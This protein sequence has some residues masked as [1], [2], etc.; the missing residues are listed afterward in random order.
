MSESELILLQRWRDTR[1]ADAF[2]TLALRHT[3]MVFNTCRRILGNHADAEEV[4]QDCLVDLALTAVPPKTHVAG[5]LHRVATYKA[6]NRVRI[7]HR[8]KQRNHRYA[9]ENARNV[10]VDWDDLCQYLDEALAQLPDKHRSPLVMSFFE[11]QSHEAIARALGLTRGTVTYR[12]KKGIEALRKQLKRRGV[13]VTTAS[14]LGMLAIPAANAAATPP[15][16]ANGIARLALAGMK[17]QAAATA[18]T[19]TAIAKAA[20]LWGGILAMKKAIVAAAIIVAAVSTGV[21]LHTQEAPPATSAQSQQENGGELATTALSTAPVPPPE[22]SPEQPPLP[23]S[24]PAKE[25]TD[26]PKYLT[27]DGAWSVLANKYA[28]RSTECDR[29]TFTTSGSR[30]RILAQIRNTRSLK[31]ATEAMDGTIRGL[32]V[33]LDPAPELGRPA[34]Q[35]LFNEELTRLVFRERRPPSAPT[36]LVFVRVPREQ[37]TEEETLEKRKQEARQLSYPQFG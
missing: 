21:V 29:A 35:G 10:T 36:T 26:A 15:A 31:K 28:Q 8:R 37:I 2:K 13:P 16:V 23:A 19:T 3:A 34:L 7:Q 24:S 22:T 12:I 14:L 27:V 18:A 5:W 9:E 25:S 33:D 11:D 30:L 1:D 20:T 17:G 32:S 6:I 4:T